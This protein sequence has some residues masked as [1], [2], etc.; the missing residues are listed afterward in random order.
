MSQR[1]GKFTKNLNGDLGYQSFQPAPLPPEPNIE[2]TPDMVNALIAA[3]KKIERLENLSAYV[4]SVQLFL[5]MYVRREAL[6]SSQIEGTQAS[7][8][9]ILDTEIEKTEDIHDVVNYVTALEFAQKE[10]Q[11]LPI[12]SRLLKETHKKLMSGVRGQE[13]TPGEYRIS[14]NWIGGL[15]SSLATARFIPPNVKDLMDGIAQ[16]E[17]YVNETDYEDDPLIRVALIH[18]QFET[19]HPFLDGNGRIGR[20]LIILYMLEQKVVTS[21][22]LYPSFFLKLNKIEYFDRLSEVRTKGA[23]EQWVLFFLLALEKS[24]ED[25]IQIIEALVLLHEETEKTLQSA[26]TQ[27]KNMKKLLPILEVSPIFSI[28]ILAEKLDCSDVTASTVIQQGVSMGILK[29]ISKGN[30]NQRFSYEKYLEILRRGT[31]IPL[32]F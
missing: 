6:L 26:T 16:L 14:Q 5:S 10:L 28:K 2:Y 23:Y 15:G 18:Y 22:L 24:A 29:K 12:S 25:S 13:K 7:L 3:H 27:K 17:E 8:D 4:P 31:D 1:S 11:R 20:M 32:D 30:R 19:L 9:D 21:P